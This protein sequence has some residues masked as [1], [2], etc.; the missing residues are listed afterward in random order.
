MPVKWLTVGTCC[1][2]AVALGLQHIH[3]NFGN[4][5]SL[6]PLNCLVKADGFVCVG[7]YGF[8]KMKEFK[9]ALVLQKTE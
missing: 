2:H 7:D 6:R 8:N 9:L 5:G 3:E 4:H 1:F